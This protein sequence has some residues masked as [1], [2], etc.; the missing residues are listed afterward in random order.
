MAYT[1]DGI[2]IPKSRIALASS[3]E[4]II[5]D[6]AGECGLTSSNAAHGMG[7]ASLFKRIVEPGEFPSVK[8]SREMRAFLQL[9]PLVK[10]AE[11]YFVVLKAIERHP[12]RIDELVAYP[13]EEGLYIPFLAAFREIKEGYQESDKVWKD[14]A[15]SF[16]AAF[17]AE[18]DRMK[19]ADYRGWLDT[20]SPFPDS[21]AELRYLIRTQYWQN[22]ELVSG[23]IP[24]FATTKPGDDVWDLCKFYSSVQKLDPDEVAEEPTNKCLITQQR[25][26][27][28]EVSTD[29]LVQMENITSR[30]DIPREQAWRV[31]DRYAPEGIEK[32]WSGGFVN[33]FIVPGYVFPWD[34]EMAAKDP[35]VRLLERK[36][37]A[38]ALG[39]AA[40]ELGF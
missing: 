19:Q 34:V 8:D 12:E 14:P 15:K 11:E 4:G 17:K 24:Y 33:Q 25:I 26:I 40:E 13:K 22:G 28:R 7:E 2:Y 5:N 30:E 37:F 1:T 39:R 10:V 35:K 23:F 36:G 6:G 9:R 3:F 38:K 16:A 29:T 18:R 32:L 31:D 20:Q 27:G 21:I